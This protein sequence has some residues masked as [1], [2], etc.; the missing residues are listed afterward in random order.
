MGSDARSGHDTNREFPGEPSLQATRPVKRSAS[1]A[2]QRRII[3]RER[4]ILLHA[5]EQIEADGMAIKA[6]ALIVAARRKFVVGAGK[7]FAYA[8]LL[9]GDLSAGL[10][11]VTLI[12]G[13]IVRPLDILS[14]VR[15][16][17]VLIAFSVNP[18]RRYT[19]DFSRQFRDAG[20][21]VVAVTD[22]PDTPI[23]SIASVN[24]VV[25]TEN[26]P[27][28]DSPTALVAAI[29]LLTAL[30][31]ASAKGARRRLQ[32]RAQLTRALDIYFDES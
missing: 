24:V 16:T 4:R 13:A 32:R 18:Y 6:T 19:I 11:Q 14:D 27:E 23:C 5:F 20:G 29:H 7:S 28:D 1:V 21:T 25:P 10:S 31:T 12:D 8:S 2:L 9:A 17:D 3:E 22:A 30:A 15:A 26:T